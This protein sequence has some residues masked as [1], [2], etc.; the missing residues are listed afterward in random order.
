MLRALGSYCHRRHRVVLLVWA[1]L[2]LLGLGIGGQVFGRLYNPGGSTSVESVQAINRLD[3][4]STSGKRLLALV[5]GPAVSD[6]AT[7]AAVVKAAAAVRALPHVAAVYDVYE[8]PDPALRATDGRA[9]VVAIDLVTGLSDSGADGVASQVR[10]ALSGIPHAR[11]LVG[12]NSV[13]RAE[14][15]KQVGLDLEHGELVSLPIAAVVLVLIFGGLAA[16]GIPLAAALVSISGSLLFL[17]GFTYLFDVDPNVVSVVTVMGLGLAIDYG[18]L[19]VSRYREEARRG[20]DEPQALAA[21]MST[22]ARSILFSALTVAAAL[23]GLFAFDDP[24]YRSMGAGGVSVVLV[25]LVAALT[26][27]PA[28]LAVRRPH[29]V[30]QRTR[31]PTSLLARMSSP[32]PEQGFFSAVTRR[33]QRHPVLVVVTLVLLLAATALPFR[34]ARFQN[35]AATSLPR[36]FVARQVNEALN[37]RFPGNHTDPVQVVGEV[38]ATDPRVIAYA[39]HLRAMPSISSVDVTAVDAGLSVVNVYPRDTGQSPH[40]QR[41]VHDLRAARPPY[42]SQVTGTLAFLV[43]FEHQ[44][45]AGLPW[46]GGL[47]A[48]AT[49]VLLFLMTGSLLVPVKALVMNVLSLGASFGA[50]VWVFQEGH[51]SG[52]LGFEKAGAI[53][54]WVPVIV[55]VFA[56]GLSMD[57]EVFLLARVKELHDAGW[58]NDDAVAMGLQRSGR[59]ITSAALLIVIVFA[60]FTGGRMIGI[61]E[62]GLSLSIA[63]IIDATLVRCLLVPATMTLLGEANWWAP[64]PLRL[65]HNRFGLSESDRLGPDIT[66]KTPQTMAQRSI[67]GISDSTG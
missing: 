66:P 42:P 1:V 56:F 51:L 32:A 9:S 12:G 13:A 6:P 62:L 8:T 63:V 36:E 33:S 49:F 47:I 25:A 38:A 20:L 44:V 37:T 24:T 46:A 64:R 48:L 18:L 50:L 30:R 7:R 31:P 52:L 61:K 55:F 35:G 43:D 29:W 22:A 45:L 58:D 67:S 4:A 41:L 54:V 65:L 23:S 53:E 2:F 10:T 19:M 39:A 27:V 34:H 5:D 59:I 57:Y 21:M 60:G 15:N 3:A 11:V 40:A 14:A 28:L 16:A 17:L 26:L